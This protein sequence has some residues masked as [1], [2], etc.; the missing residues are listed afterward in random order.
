M[1]ETGNTHRIITAVVAE[2]VR[3][4]IANARFPISSQL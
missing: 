2:S 1:N 4:N 3:I